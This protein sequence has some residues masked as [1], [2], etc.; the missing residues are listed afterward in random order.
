ME[1]FDY[2]IRPFANTPLSFGKRFSPD[3]PIFWETR[4]GATAAAQQASTQTSIAATFWTAARTFVG[5]QLSGK[6]AKGVLGGVLEVHT[7]DLPKH[8]LVFGEDKY[9]PNSGMRE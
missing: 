7:S 9:S 6:N 1:A 5:S 2:R 8:R 3:D 4:E